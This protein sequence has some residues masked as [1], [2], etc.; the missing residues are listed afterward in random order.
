MQPTTGSTDSASRAT[1]PVAEAL[2]A[3]AA[4]LRA[5]V[6]RVTFA[7]PVAY[8]YNPLDYAWA[9]HVGYLSR[10]G[11]SPRRVLFLGMN[12]GPWGMAQVGVPF[13]EVSVVR[14]WLGITG[15]VTAPAKA[16]PAKPVDGFGCGRSEVSGRR[17]WGLFAERFGSAEA[18]FRDH[19]VGNYCPLMLL[20]E[21][22]RN[23]TPDRLRGAAREALEQACD[24][25]LRRVVAVLQPQ[26][27]I[28]IG[29]FAAGRARE[30]LCGLPV[31]VGSVLHPSPA[32]PAANRGW[33]GAAVRQLADLG[34]W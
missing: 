12:P 29:N 32:S 27:V 20:D 17:L 10:W 3:A 18:F 22:G 28:G 21:G 5:T 19:F 33:A 24:A 9:P 14:D 15:T 11:S 4:E 13:G 7:A 16:H 1:T 2:I 30:A 26:W 8:V 34:V 6:D 25:H 31:Q 23:L